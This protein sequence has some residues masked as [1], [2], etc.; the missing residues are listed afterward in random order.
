SNWDPDFGA[1]SQQALE[2]YQMTWGSDDLDDI[3]GVVAVDLDVLEALLE[4]TGGQTVEA[5]GFGEIYVTSENAFMELERVTRAPE[6]T[7]RRSKAAVGSL[8]E[9]LIRD[10]LALPVS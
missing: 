9:H 5:P 10:V 7:W 1:W 6:D 8:Q 3:S 2:F 4:I